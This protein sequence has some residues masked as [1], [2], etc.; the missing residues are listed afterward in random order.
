L[1]VGVENEYLSAS[2]EIDFDPPR[3][4]GKV[5]EDLALLNSSRTCVRRVRCWLFAR[6]VFCFLFPMVLFFA[7]IIYSASLRAAA[8]H[9]SKM[10]C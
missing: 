5:G 7:A 3:N 4:L 8:Y 2:G 1:A 10:P 9:E 6:G